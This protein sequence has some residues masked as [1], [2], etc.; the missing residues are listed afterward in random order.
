MW[1][2]GSEHH[3]GLGPGP[4]T[5]LPAWDT[6]AHCPESWGQN[7]DGQGWEGPPG[8]HW[9]GG[10]DLCSGTAAA[11]VGS[12]GGFRG[13]RAGLSPLCSAGTATGQ[14]TQPGGTPAAT[15]PEGK[16]LGESL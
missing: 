4:G 9:G 15:L 1:R 8:T 16:V 14:V 12:S 5:E 10:V 3:L 11:G 6:S 2:A 7:R 13:P